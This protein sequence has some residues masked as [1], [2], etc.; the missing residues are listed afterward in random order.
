VADAGSK[1]GTLL[2]G[3]KLAPKKPCALASGN[4]VRV[5]QLELTFLSSSGFLKLLKG[6]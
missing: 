3:E 2:S 6:R 5:G 4:K 1:N